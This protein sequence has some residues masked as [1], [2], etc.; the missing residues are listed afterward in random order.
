MNN[1]ADVS[2]DSK[3]VIHINNKLDDHH[4]NQFSDDVTKLDGVLSAALQE[5][6]PQL[7]IVA[8]NPLQ[9]KAVEV[10]NG[11]RNKGMPAQIISWL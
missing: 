1:L 7:M 10:V 6:C 5:K 3:I 11:I 2:C 8:F 4:K 9:T